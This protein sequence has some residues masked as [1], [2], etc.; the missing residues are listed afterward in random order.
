[1]GVWVR[2]VLAV[3]AVAGSLSMVTASLADGG[4][5]G[6]L[7]HR[8]SLV[9]LS[10]DPA[11]PPGSVAL[12]DLPPVDSGYCRGATGPQAGPPNTVFGRLTIAGADAPAGTV[13]QIF[14]DGSAGP[15]VHTAAAGGYRLDYAAG[16]SDCPNHVGALISVAAGGQRFD[17]GVHVGDEAANPFLRLDVGA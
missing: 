14:F 2:G 15:A 7:G 5:S 8:L 3:A 13:V 1:M 6:P 16:G 17:N 9:Q 4:P 11:P 10:F 12:A